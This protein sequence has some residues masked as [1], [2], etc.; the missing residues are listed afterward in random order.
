MAI[1]ATT[2]VHPNPGTSWDD[3]QKQLKRASGLARKHGAE[4]VTVLVNMVGGPGTN[5]IGFLTTAQDWAT[6]GRI[7][8]ALTSDPDFQGLMVDAGQIATW[9]NYVSQT[10]EVE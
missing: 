5:S 6:Y 8:E 4:N 1:L 2:I 3:I 10:I 7:Q 9:E